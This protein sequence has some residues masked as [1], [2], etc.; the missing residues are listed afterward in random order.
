MD[1]QKL[2][3]IQSLIDHKKFDEAY[4][5]LVLLDQETNDHPMDK[6]HIYRMI[7]A[8]LK[9]NYSQDISKYHFYDLKKILDQTQTSDI[10]LLIQ[11]YHSVLEVLAMVHD[12]QAHY[13][14]YLRLID[15]YRQKHDQKNIQACYQRIMQLIDCLKDNMI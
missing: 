8:V 7:N 9:M 15:L 6:L 1:L 4:D 3:D 13:D 11:G 5:K 2:A 14:I 12:F 10:D